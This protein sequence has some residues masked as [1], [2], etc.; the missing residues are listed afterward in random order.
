MT[1]P[2]PEAFRGDIYSAAGGLPRRYLLRDRRPSEAISTPRP[3]FGGAR[4]RRASGGRA[5]L[6]ALAG[7]DLLR[8]GDCGRCREPSPPR[9]RHLLGG[10]E[11]ARPKRARSGHGVS[12][13]STVA[14]PSR[15]SRRWRSR[16]GSI[17]S[18]P[19]D[20]SSASTRCSLA[21]T[22]STSVSPLRSSPDASRLTCDG[23][24]RA[25]P[26]IFSCPPLR[27]PFTLGTLASS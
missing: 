7:G 2:R 17:V 1:T 9:H 18:K 4:R 22:C 11:A 19:R 8:R 26:H 14:S 20:S 5:A 6:V 21:A 13:G 24:I 12:T 10:P 25:S 3:A 23:G 15:S 27:A 16:Q